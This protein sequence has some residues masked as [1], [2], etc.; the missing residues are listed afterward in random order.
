MVLTATSAST[1]VIVSTS[2]IATAT[3]VS[4]ATT[5]FAVTWWDGFI[6]MHTLALFV[7][8][9]GRRKLR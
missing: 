4:R 2:G 6:A 3:I 7:S 8:R 9:F 1:R 5:A